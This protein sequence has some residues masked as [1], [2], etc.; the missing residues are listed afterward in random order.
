M[1]R[2]RGKKKNKS[3]NVVFADELVTNVSSNVE[4]SNAATD[5][6]FIS[7]KKEK[8]P[9]SYANKAEKLSNTNT[10]TCRNNVPLK[11]INLD[12]VKDNVTDLD[13]KRLYVHDF[14]QNYWYL[15]NRYHKIND[16]I[17]EPD[18]DDEE[19]IYDEY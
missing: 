11:T 8:K 9:M 17:I 19:L 7:V 12:I 14:L 6:G 16:I 18:S 3:Q 2:N 4:T 13:D 5:D 10:N 1:G 15:V